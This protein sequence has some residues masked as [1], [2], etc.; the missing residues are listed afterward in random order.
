[1]KFIF[2]MEMNIKVFYKV[3]LSFWLFVNRHAQSSQIILHVF[4]ISSEKY[5]GGIFC[6][7]L[8][9]KVLYK[10]IVSLWVCVARHAQNTE[11]NK[12]ATSLQKLK[13]NMKDE[14]EFLPAEKRQ[15]LQINTIILY[16]CGQ[17]C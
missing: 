12:F 3:I 5:Q 17:A 1:M 15:R 16:V 13:E 4:V 6:L 14:G 11:N 2:G 8:K 10:L 7:Q 9:T